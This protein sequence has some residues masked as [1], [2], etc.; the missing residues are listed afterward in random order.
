MLHFTFK[1]HVLLLLVVLIGFTTACKKKEDDPKPTTPVVLGPPVVKGFRKQMDYS[2]LTPTTSYR[3]A[4]LDEAGDSTVD[5]NE[6]RNRLRMFR[7]LATYVSSSITAN[8]T[9]DAEKLKNMYA[10]VGSPFDAPYTDLNTLKINIK[11]V[12]GSSKANQSSVH[13]HMEDAFVK[14]AAI[15][16][17]GGETAAEGTAGKSGNYLLDAN[18]IEWAQIIQKSLIGAYHLDYISNVLLNTGLNADNTGLVAGKKYTA[19][20][21]NWDLAY[22][23][24]TMND[25][26]Y[27]GTTDEKAAK[28]ASE[29]YLGSYVW[30]YNKSGFVKLHMAFLRGRAA[31]VNNDMTEVKAQAAIIRQILEYAIGASAK[32][33]M[34][35]SINAPHAFAEGLGFIY[36][37]RFCSVTGADD[38]FSDDLTDDLFDTEQTTFYD[39]TATQ[40][41][42]VRNKLTSKFNLQ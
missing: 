24:L 36:S 31:I 29:L 2:T 14:M 32:G 17:E 4:F 25:R 27:D 42:N 37:T 19:L 9:I 13:T 6:G 40:Y 12:A 10:N 38:A 39:I 16:T 28:L 1:N 26:Y 35:K 7:A 23:F 22:G 20:E 18:G 34:N 11:E 41:T 5:R 8:T 15:S 21:H 33:Y 30:E 3:T